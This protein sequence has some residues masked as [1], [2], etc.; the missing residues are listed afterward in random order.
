MEQRIKISKSFIW[1]RKLIFSLLPPGALEK[2]LSA[3]HCRDKYAEVF[4]RPC[5]GCILLCMTIMKACWGI[6]D[7]WGY[8]ICFLYRSHVHTQ[9]S[10]TI[11]KEVFLCS[12]F[13]PAHG[14]YVLSQLYLP[15]ELQKVFLGHIWRLNIESTL[16]KYHGSSRSAGPV[17]VGWVTSH[18]VLQRGSKECC[19]CIQLLSL[20]VTA[21][22]WI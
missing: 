17:P 20:S 18:V 16:K 19:C 15:F 12:S 22:A 11:S 2:Y 21:H 8:Q 5:W 3:F 7:E 13:Q 9:C 10:S 6:P 1:I 14:V 4:P